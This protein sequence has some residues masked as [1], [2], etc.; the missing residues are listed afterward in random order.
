MTTADVGGVAA[1]E[2]EEDRWERMSGRVW[3]VDEIEVWIELMLGGEAGGEVRN[4]SEIGGFNVG[5]NKGT[6]LVRIDWRGAERVREPPPTSHLA[7]N[8]ERTSVNA[9][10]E[11]GFT[12]RILIPF[13]L[14]VVVG[15][16]AADI[17]FATSRK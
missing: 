6:R 10:V 9:S 16:G 8:H 17:W 3:C 5:G 12:T 14:V 1:E 4:D 15:C 7:P 11:L 13:S 2:E